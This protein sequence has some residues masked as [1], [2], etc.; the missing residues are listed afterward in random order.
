MGQQQHYEQAPIAEAIIDLRVGFTAPLEVAHLDAAFSNERERYP[1]CKRLQQGLGQFEFGPRVSSSAAT[2]EIGLAF[3]SADEKQVVQFRRNGYTFSRL[4]PYESWQPFSNE[5]RRVW[6]V[7]RR[8]LSPGS[9]DRLAVRYINRIQLPRSI[10]DLSVW[11]KS[12]PEIAAGVSKSVSGFFMHVTIPQLDLNGALNLIETLD[13]G[14]SEKVGVAV[15]LDV[16]LF[17]TVDVPQDEESIWDYF[18]QL[19]VRKNDVFEACITDKTRE[20]FR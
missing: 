10:D 12:Y 8:E 6:E 20:L 7:Y 16:D 14:S 19:H 2:E 9:I 3:I 1:A 11:L 5:A 18:E 17:R 4:K 15:I 13:E